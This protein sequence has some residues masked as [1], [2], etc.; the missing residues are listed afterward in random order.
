MDQVKGS[1]IFSKFDM[2]SAYN[3]IRIREGDEYL[4]TFIT[5]QGTFQSNVM[6]FGQMNAPPP[7]STL[8]TTTF[9][10]DRN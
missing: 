3:Q 4:T 9:T 7:S 1:Q 2:K 6:G 5:H 10:K 8:W